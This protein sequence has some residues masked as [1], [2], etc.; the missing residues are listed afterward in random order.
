MGIKTRVLTPK[1]CAWRYAPVANP[2]R[3]FWYPDEHVKLYRQ[4]DPNSWDGPLARVIQD[5]KE[6]A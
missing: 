3:W 4:D 6:L 2:E 5:I 1:R